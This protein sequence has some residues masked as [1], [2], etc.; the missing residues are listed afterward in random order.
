VSGQ[1]HAPAV[2]YP[3]ERPGTHCTGGWVGP[4]VGLD[5]CG[6]SRP[7]GIRSPDRPARNQSLYRL[8]YPSPH[9]VRIYL[10]KFINWLVFD[11]ILLILYNT[12]ELWYILYICKLVRYGTV[13]GRLVYV[14]ASRK[15]FTVF[16]LRI[17]QKEYDVTCLQ[18]AIFIITTAKFAILFSHNIL[19][20]GRPLRPVRVL[21]SH[22]TQ[23]RTP[24]PV[25][26]MQHVARD[27]RI[28]WLWS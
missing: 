6:K 10:N 15:R 12:A 9:S 11:G 8:N 21:T 22:V 3:R 4:R 7:T 1:R 5:M 14:P 16:I 24:Q 20:R 27:T 19:K 28:S 25:A 23:C 2:L 18:A 13:Q 26:R 17:M